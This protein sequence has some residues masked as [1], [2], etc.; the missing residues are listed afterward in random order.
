MN[1][2]TTAR[3]MIE[4]STAFNLRE[5]E[6][7][8]RRIEGYFVVFDDIYQIS[9]MMSESV[10]PHALDNAI[11]GDVRALIDHQTE[12]VLG[13]TAAH[14]LDLKIDSHGLWGSILINP[15][16]Q[17]ANNCLARVERGDV[18]QASFG[19][20]ILREDTEIREDGS[21]HWTIKEI[22]LYEV[23]VCTFPA[24]ESTELKAR[25][26]DAAVVRKREFDAW[27]AR[28]EK[29]HEWLRK[30]SENA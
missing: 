25:S 7:G 1:R 24:Y 10:D 23:S 13:R 27:K 16:D 20:D 30:E 3:Q 17:D 9:P 4:R 15:N 5:I 21:I 12:K 28:I 26:A 11:S 18:N 29:S 22:K 8:E 6:N 14:T 2:E 19:F